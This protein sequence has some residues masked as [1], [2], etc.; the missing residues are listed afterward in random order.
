MI[1]KSE[2]GL[3]SKDK[4]YSSLTVKELVMKVMNMVLKFGISLR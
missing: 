2:E 3:S 1:E 4:F